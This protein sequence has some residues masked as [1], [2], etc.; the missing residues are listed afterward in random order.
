MRVVNFRPHVRNAALFT[1]GPGF[2]ASSVRTYLDGARGVAPVKLAQAWPGPKPEQAELMAWAW[3]AARR[4]QSFVC[5]GRLR[6]SVP[7][8]RP[9]EHM[10]TGRILRAFPLLPGHQNIIVR[11]FF[12]SFFANQSG[13]LYAGCMQ[14]SVYAHVVSVQRSLLVDDP[15]KRSA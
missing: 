1:T 11:V 4:S 2:I 8:R 9:C 15:M 5:M 7:E 14:W 12:L 10:P 13:S 6:S 3:E